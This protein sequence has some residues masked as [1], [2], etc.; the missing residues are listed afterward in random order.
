MPIEAPAGP[1][2]PAHGPAGDSDLQG[3]KT[4]R[5]E[6]GRVR[7]A[8]LAVGVLAAACGSHSG[9]G[10]GDAGT[11]SP[12]GPQAGGAT[13]IA[14]AVMVGPSAGSG[15]VTRIVVDANDVGTLLWIGASGVMAS[16][17]SPSAG[18][19]TPT[20]LDTG[21]VDPTR[22]NLGIDLDGNVTAQW[23][24]I[25]AESTG[26]SVRIRQYLAGGQGWTAAQDPGP[27][28]IVVGG[29]GQVALVATSGSCSG[30][31]V[32]LRVSGAWAP[33][34]TL[35]A[36]SGLDAGASCFAFTLGPAAFSSSGDL[37]VTWSVSTANSSNVVSTQS[38][39]ARYVAANAGWAAPAPLDMGASWLLPDGSDH[40]TL[41]ALQGAEGDAGQTSW[42]ASEQFS[43]GAWSPR[44]DSAPRG[45]GSFGNAFQ[46]ASMGQG[47]AAVVAGDSVQVNATYL[48]PSSGWQNVDVP[49]TGLS[50]TGT[51]FAGVDAQGRAVVLWDAIVSENIG[52][53]GRVFYA[54]Y[55][56][57][58]GWTSPTQ[59]DGNVGVV[60]DG[61]AGV[62]VNDSGFTLAAWATENAVTDAANVWAAPLP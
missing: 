31:S 54:R 50:A 22:F 47:G 4:M 2:L 18:W 44:M 25:A 56:P 3:G 28:Q 35:G 57:T 48:A 38:F 12:E 11:A 39:F 43:G 45:G 16:R 51:V 41:V 13:P 55:N 30:P 21:T 29:H 7:S 19:S 14:G 59:I 34:T 33:A 15:L 23:A 52:D 60:A 58:S 8:A 27:G 26:G 1:P 17:Y 62:A 49:G 32:S 42:V 10:S 9:A 61:A 40:M 5:K 53:V 46:V 36:S 24:T 6:L 37:F 20:Q